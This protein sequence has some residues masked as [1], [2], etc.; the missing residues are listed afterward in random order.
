MLLDPQ[1]NLP[2]DLASYARLICEVAVALQHHADNI[3]WLAVDRLP[4]A[5]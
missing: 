1:D 4:I 2:T 3:S 5:Q